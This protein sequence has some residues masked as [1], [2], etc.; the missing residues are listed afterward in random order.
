MSAR[1]WSIR[2][3]SPFAFSARASRLIRLIALLAS[4]GGR[5]RPWRLAVPSSPCS[6]NTLRSS[7][8]CSYRSWAAAG[9]TEMISRLQMGSQ[10]TGGHRRRPHQGSLGDFSGQFLGEGQ[11]QI[12]RGSGPEPGRS[13][14]HGAPP[15]PRVDVHRAENASSTWISADRRVSD[16]AA[17]T[18]EEAVSK[19]SCRVGNLRIVQLGDR[20]RYRLD[21]GIQPG[22][23]NE[24]PSEHQPS[25]RRTRSNPDNRSRSTEDRITPSSR[26][27][28]IVSRSAGSPLSS[29]QSVSRRSRSEG[30]TS[31]SNIRSS[32]QPTPDRF[33][34]L[35]ARS[36]EFLRCPSDDPARPQPGDLLDRITQLPQHR[37]G[38][39]PQHRWLETHRGRCFRHLDGQAQGA[40]H[41]GD[42]VVV[43]HHH[44]S[45][46]R[47]RAGQRFGDSIDG[48]GR[49]PDAIEGLD[50]LRPAPGRHDPAHHLI[51]EFSVSNPFRISGKTGVSS[52]LRVPDLPRQHCELSVVAH[53]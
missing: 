36:E 28:G 13:T 53:G 6:E 47:L 17:W 22:P 14:R 39:R 2:R 19:M 9:S 52:P 16:N 25:S 42:A 32:L 43:L 23:E 5:L 11:G 49:D 46:Q 3:L 48:A 4:A 15:R 31:A 29:S 33:Q 24:P 45:G 35:V 51:D 26:P 21:V 1:I 30:R 27:G 44:L 34:T 50:P 18:S 7:S 38:V 41:P 20:L 37:I 40:D 10:L 8:F 12:A